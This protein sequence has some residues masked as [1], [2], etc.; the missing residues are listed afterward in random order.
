MASLRHI[1]KLALRQLEGFVKSL[2]LLLKIDLRVPDFSRLSRR[3]AGALSELSYP[4]PQESIHFVIDSSGLK[5]YGEQE[6]IRTKQG[7]TYKRKVWR[8][9]HIGVEGK[10]VLLASQMTTHK[11]DDRACFD[12]LI[13]KVGSEFIT[14]TLADTGYDS[15][16]AY[17]QCEDRS[18]TPLIPPPERSN[19]SSRK[20][21]SSLRNQTVAYIK[22]FMLG[23]L[24]I[25]LEE[26]IVLRTLFSG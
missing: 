4:S 9:I 18:I 11:T 21:F 24:N 19:L 12:S 2:L 3:M 17:H 26:G 14:E 8:K 6:W 25:I 13:D 7:R 5:V 23:K 22:V 16:K 1:F 20:G 15:H 10:G